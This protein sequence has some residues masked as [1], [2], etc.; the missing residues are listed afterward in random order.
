[1]CFVLLVFAVVVL[2]LLVLAVLGWFL[3]EDDVEQ[4][5]ASA[6]QEVN[7]QAAMD[8]GPVANVVHPDEFPG[9]STS[10]RSRRA[11]TSPVPAETL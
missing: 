6:V 8:S 4:F 3:E 5:I 2:L 11:R 1:M 9:V 7:L 10:S